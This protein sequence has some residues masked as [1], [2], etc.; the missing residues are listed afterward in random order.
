MSGAPGAILFPCVS[1]R[2]L[3]RSLF[4][5]LR[6]TLTSLIGDHLSPMFTGFGTLFLLLPVLLLPPLLAGKSQDPEN[7]GSMQTGTLNLLLANKRGFVIAADSRAT[8]MSPRVYSDNSQKLFRVGPRAAAVI[9]G[10]A[11]ATYG[12]QL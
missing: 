7:T 6:I 10:F 8:Q 12:A 2:A 5:P 3:G 1:A 4:V 9:A 11:S